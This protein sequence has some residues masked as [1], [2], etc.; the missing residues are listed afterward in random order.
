MWISILAWHDRVD[1]GATAPGH[2][3]QGG[4][5][6]CGVHAGTTAP[7]PLRPPAEAGHQRPHQVQRFCQA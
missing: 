2:V 1:R 5:G 4:A 7:R 3:L 6:I